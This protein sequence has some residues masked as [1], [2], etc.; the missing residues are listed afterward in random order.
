MLAIQQKQ[1]DKTKDA[2]VKIRKIEKELAKGIFDNF[3]FFLEYSG[4]QAKEYA[5]EW[6]SFYGK[7]NLVKKTIS[8]GANINCSRGCALQMAI[9]NGHYDIVI[10][11]VESG[12]LDILN[13]ENILMEAIENNQINILKYFL[14]DK[15]IF[16]VKICNVHCSFDLPLRI[17]IEMGSLE[18]VELLIK[19]GADINVF[20]GY[21]LII[22]AKFGHF[23]IVELLIRTGVNKDAIPEAIQVAITSNHS[24][25]VDLL[26]KYK[27]NKS[28]AVNINSYN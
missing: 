7:L 2:F 23:E 9:R 12:T 6:A 11:L 19:Y 21:P 16:G 28:C 25:I 20:D 8:E 3:D 4:K 15:N 26:E 18:V 13:E 10:Y 22:S 14:D 17:A 27:T 5:L 1:I 24:V